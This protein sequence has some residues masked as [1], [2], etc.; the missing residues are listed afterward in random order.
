MGMGWLGILTVLL[1]SISGV[2]GAETSTF[3]LTVSC[4]R[5]PKC[6]QELYGECAFP[7]REAPKTEEEARERCFKEAK[8]YLATGGRNCLLQSPQVNPCRLTGSNDP[9]H[10]TCTMETK[11]CQ[12]PSGQSQCP[13][14]W[15][16]RGNSRPFDKFDGF[17]SLGATGPIWC[18][19]SNYASGATTQ[20]R[21][22]E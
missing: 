13:Q 6:F 3:K 9:T 20:D 21:G 4:K 5:P 12:Q 17:E 2:A 11:N 22:N 19:K 10:F 16:P 1:S 8:R 14:G 18:V 7:Y 15:S